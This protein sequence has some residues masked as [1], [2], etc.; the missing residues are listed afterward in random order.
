MNIP[1]LAAAVA[2]TVLVL[3]GSAAGAKGLTWYNLI[4]DTWLVGILPVTLYPFF[5]GN[6][7]AGIGA[8]S[9]R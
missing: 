7:G 4:A 6:T 2:I 1:V 9:R 3:A 8:R 5:G